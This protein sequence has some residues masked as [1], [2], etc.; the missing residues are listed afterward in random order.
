MLVSGDANPAIASV[1]QGE[2]DNLAEQFN[3]PTR[4]AVKVDSC[5]EDNAFY[6][7][8]DKLI[9]FCSEYVDLWVLLYEANT[10]Q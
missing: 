8:D 3:L 10:P 7:P 4:I 1:L 5:G 2:I 9:T 6:M